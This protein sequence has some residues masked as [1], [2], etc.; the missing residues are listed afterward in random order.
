MTLPESVLVTNGDLNA[1]H[2]EYTILLLEEDLVLD[3]YS[4]FFFSN[5]T[6]PVVSD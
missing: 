2:E 3:I 6:S 1:L 5:N 4:L